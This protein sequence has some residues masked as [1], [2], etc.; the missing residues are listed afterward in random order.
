[1]SRRVSRPARRVYLQARTICAPTPIAPAHQ[2]F[3]RENPAGADPN[4]VDKSGVAPLHRAV[5]NRSAAAVR[6]LID[7]GADPRA[8]NRNGSTP[9]ISQ[10][11]TPAVAGQDQLR[12][13]RNR[14]RF[15]AFSRS[16]GPRERCLLRVAFDR[17]Y[18]HLVT[19]GLPSIAL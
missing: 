3:S 15:R 18:R 4:A 10:L 14:K 19:V 16:M 11:G 2:R 9:L 6:A 7:G 17:G 5:R 8:P 12:Q 13:R 1:M